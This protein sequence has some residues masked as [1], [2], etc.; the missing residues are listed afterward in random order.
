[1]TKATSYPPHEH[2][3]LPGSFYHVFNRTN[4]REDLFH[5]EENRRYFLE[6]FATYLLPFLSVYAYCL[7]DNHF[8]FLV[9]IREEEALEKHLHQLAKQTIIQ[10]KLLDQ[11]AHLRSW[12]ELISSQFQRFFTSYA[13]SVNKEWGR[14]GNLF[15]RPFK[16]VAVENEGYFTKLIYYIHANPKKHGMQTAFRG[17]SWSSYATILSDHPTKLERELV[18]EWFGG[19]AA[20]EL[21]HQQQEEW[22]EIDHLIIE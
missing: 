12:D 10:K 17:Y 13:M 7:L 3:L 14:K 21:F 2:P 18:L 16:R 19:K 9:R 22:Q 6:K 4:N 1:M 20:F 8:H 11:P 15:Y 5:S